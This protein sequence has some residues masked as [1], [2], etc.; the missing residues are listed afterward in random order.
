[1]GRDDV[2]EYDVAPGRRSRNH[3]GARFDLVGND[4]IIA[5]VQVLPALNTDDV[6]ACA[7]DIRTHGIQKICNVN[8]VGFP[9]GII[10]NRPAFGTAGGE[11][12]IYRCTDACNIEID[13]RTDEPIRLCGD[14]CAA[15]ND[16]RTERSH[17]LDME[18]HR[19]LTYRAASGLVDFRSTVAAEERAE[20]IIGC[21]EPAC[22]L[23][24]HDIPVNRGRIY[25]NRTAAEIGYP[26]AEL[27]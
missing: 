10:Y 18:I 25:L 17:A 7:A 8:D 27:R 5:A 26:C 14:E 13:I 2:I 3:I 6:R 12:D 19:A 23:G 4:S 11:H 21:S 20:H 24:C 22:H 15:F 1:M 9:C 16:F